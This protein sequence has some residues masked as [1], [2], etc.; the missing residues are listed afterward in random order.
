MQ[1]RT[2]LT[3]NKKMFPN[4]PYKILRQINHD[5]DNPT[6]AQKKLSTMWSKGSGPMYYNPYDLLNLGRRSPHRRWNHDFRMLMMIGYQLH[7]FNGVKVAIS[8]AVA[9][10]IS[11]KM[12]QSVGRKNRDLFELLY[13]RYYGQD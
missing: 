2:H 4:I 7:G 8:H 1:T 9:D 6:Q 5:I 13:D 3:W 12:R 11:D 10:H